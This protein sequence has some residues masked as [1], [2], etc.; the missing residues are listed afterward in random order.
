MRHLRTSQLGTLLNKSAPSRAAILGLSLLGALSGLA[1]GLMPVAM[2]AD[3]P[4]YNMTTKDGHFTPDMFEVPAGK[5]FKIVMKNDGLGPE[6]FESSDLHREKVAM[7]GQS[8]EI[9]LG[10]LKP[11]TYGFFGE[12]HPETAKGKIVVK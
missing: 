11:G 8:I 12:F 5:K 7:P 4:V 10:P 9:L 2:A 1:F 6:E 3:M